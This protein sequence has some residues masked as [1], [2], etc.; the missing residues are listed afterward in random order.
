[1]FACRASSRTFSKVTSSTNRALDISVGSLSPTINWG[2]LAVQE[3]ALPPLDA[4][5]RIIELLRDSG[6]AAA[7]ITASASALH[8]LIDCYVSQAYRGALGASEELRRT[9]DFG[10]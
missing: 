1:M 5:R 2:T 4:Q 9:A 10:T 8:L 3:F 6:D 7:T